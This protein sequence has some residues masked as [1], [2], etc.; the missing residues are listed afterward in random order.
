MIKKLLILLLCVSSALSENPLKK[1]ETHIEKPIVIGNYDLEFIFKFIQYLNE[2]HNF[3]TFIIISDRR[4]YTR[5]AYVI[6]RFLERALMEEFGIPIVV[7]GRDSVAQL[8]YRIGINNLVFV[9]I[10]SVRDP[11]LKVVSNVLKG[12]HHTPMVFIFK[13]K[14]NVPPTL[15]DIRE[16]FEWCWAENILNVALTYQVILKWNYTTNSKQLVVKNAVFNYT[17]FPK[18]RI[19]N[20]TEQV[21]ENKGTFIKNNIKDLQG[22]RFSTPMFMDPPNV[23]LTRYGRHGNKNIFDFITGTAGRTY[24]EFIHFVNGS[25]R[26]WPAHNVSFYHFQRKTLHYAAQKL[27]DIGIHPYSSLLPYAN[28]TEGSYPIAMT[29]ACLV[30]PVIPEI[31]HREYIIRVMPCTIWLLWLME[32]FSLII[33]QCIHLGRLDMGSGIIYAFRTLMS[34]SMD[35]R[36]FLKRRNLL[37]SLHLF[38]VL[39][40]VLFNC[41]FSASLTSILSTTLVGE[42]ITSVEDLL[43]SGL[44]IITTVH[45]KEVYFDQKLFPESL[46]SLLHIVSDVELM[47]HKD[48]LNTSYAYVFNNEEWSKYDFQQQLLGKPLLRYAHTKDLCTVQ[49]FLRFPVQWDSPFMKTFERFI[50]YTTDSGIRKHWHD[51]SIYQAT[52]MKL[53][54]MWKPDDDGKEKLLTMDHFLTIIMCYAMLISGAILCFIGELLWFNRKK[55]WE[56][57]MILKHCISRN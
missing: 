17:P 11:L 36:E 9:Y 55:M 26:I 37:K 50:V 35:T 27:I 42:Q 28:I 1:L 25:L 46:N 21:S 51:L 7:L 13:R 8:R 15:K 18:L 32:M 45:E 56:K 40:S 19:F 47:E 57:W 4:E 48:N 12:I 38:V 39:L 24:H 44:K 41:G 31:A 5:A 10:A 14:K 22:Y 53:V 23:F 54:Q 6:V 20:V 43:A 33:I 52:H 2:I 3:N 29:N 30:V 34:Q 16:F 49:L